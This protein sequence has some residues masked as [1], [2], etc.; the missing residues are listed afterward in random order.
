MVTERLSTKT[1]SLVSVL[2]NKPAIAHVWWPF[3]LNEE[4]TDHEKVLSLWLNSTLGILCFLPYTSATSTQWISMKKENLETMPILDPRKLSR[5]QIKLM[6]RLYDKVRQ[7]QFL[8]L[9]Q[10]DKDR[11]RILIDNT[12]EKMLSLPSIEEIRELLAHEP[13][14][15]VGGAALEEGDED[16]IDE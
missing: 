12:I 11:T 13:I 16:P 5:S 14:M 6:V 2:L 10:I 15:S 1:N 7:Q 3:K 8:P 4:N 9:S